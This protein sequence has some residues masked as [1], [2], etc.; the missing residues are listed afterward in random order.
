MKLFSRLLAAVSCALVGL[1]AVSASGQ[2]TAPNGKI[3]YQSLDYDIIVID[4]DGTNAVN[5]TNS[6]DAAEFGPVWSP[7]GSKIAFVQSHYYEETEYSHEEIWVMDSDGSNRVNLTKTR[8]NSEFSPSWSPR[9]DKIVFVKT[10]PHPQISED[11]GIFVMDADGGNVTSLTNAQ[12]EIPYEETGPAWAPDGSAIAYAGVFEGR[13]QIMA[14][15]PDGSNKRMLTT[16]D[17]YDHDRNPAWSPDSSKIT[18]MREIAAEG[19]QWDIYIMN[20]DGSGQTN[21]TQHPQA[22]MF[23][24]FSPDGS[25]VAFLSNRDTWD[26]MDIYLID[27][28]VLASAPPEPAL[29][30]STDATTEATQR[31]RVTRLRTG[32]AAGKLS[33]RT[34]AG[35][36][37]AVTDNAFKAASVTVAQGESV[38]W[39][40]NGQNSHTVTDSSGMDL[41]DSGVAEPGAPRFFVNFGAAGIYHYKCDLHHGMTGTVRVPIK[42]APATAGMNATFTVTWSAVPAPSGYVYDVQIKRPGSDKFVDWRLARAGRKA[43]FTPDAG[44][45]EYSFRAR[46]RRLSNAAHSRYSPARK[47]T[48]TAAQ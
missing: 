6:P 8:G 43:A 17:G 12:K 7:D 31:R 27:V 20:R 44:A 15:D 3:A 36:F 18:F 4:A 33:W 5:I 1:G 42:V 22:D 10:E 13:R 14:M 23:P 35:A 32:G 21:L 39:T 28:P 38:R 47:I 11:W 25:K 30:A 9:G 2:S 24:T 34:G 26:E 45:G 48:V 29:Q 19:Y 40:F 16:A 46:M 37:V 41:F